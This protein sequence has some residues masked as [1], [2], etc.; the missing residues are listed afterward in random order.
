MAGCAYHGTSLAKYC[1]K[2]QTTYST[3]CKSCCKHYCNA[4]M[5]GS[6]KHMCV[7]NSFHSKCYTCDKILKY[8]EKPC[9]LCH[10][11]YCSDHIIHEHLVVHETQTKS[12]SMC[13]F[14]HCTKEAFSKTGRCIAHGNRVMFK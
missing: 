6:D 3:L 9:S 7:T 4:H 1:S 11:W 5:Y 14:F 8:D 2:K 10:E 12:I 13:D